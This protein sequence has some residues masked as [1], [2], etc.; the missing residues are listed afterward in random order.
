MFQVQMHLFEM[1]YPI[2]LNLQLI[3]NMY[4]L[5]FFIFTIFLIS[6]SISNYSIIF[7]NKFERALHNFQSVVVA[8]AYNPN[9]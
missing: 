1:L 5:D 2:V 9:T 3:G 4:T 7:R 8:Q 6:T